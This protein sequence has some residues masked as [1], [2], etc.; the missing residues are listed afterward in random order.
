MLNVTA[1]VDLTHA[2]LPAMM[3]RKAGGVI[4]VTHMSPLA[5][6]ARVF[7]RVMRPREKVAKPG[8]ERSATPLARRSRL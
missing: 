6:T 2:F 8:G 1:L 4:Q 7:A 3:E 5:L